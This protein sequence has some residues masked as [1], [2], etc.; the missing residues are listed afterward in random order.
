[1]SFPVVVSNEAKLLFTAEAGQATLPVPNA[2]LVTTG[3]AGSVLS[4]VILDPATTDTNCAPVPIP[5]SFVLSVAR[6]A[7]FVVPSVKVS[8]DCV[9]VWFVRSKRYESVWFAVAHVAIP[10]SLVVSVSKTRL[11]QVSLSTFRSIEAFVSLGR[12]SIF[13]PSISV[14]FGILLDPA[15]I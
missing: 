1:M 5:A 6:K 2:V 13:K 15:I 12:L 8:A 9:P 10:A 4:T 11:F 3:F 7:L 14:S